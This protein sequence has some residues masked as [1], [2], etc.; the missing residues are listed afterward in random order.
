MLIKPL[1]QVCK[2]FIMAAMRPLTETLRENT[3]VYL[4]Y[5]FS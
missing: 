5:F 3:G 4:S 1:G 2:V